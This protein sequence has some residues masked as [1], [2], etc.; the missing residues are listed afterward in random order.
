MKHI[1]V[2]G[3]GS[4][5]T[6]IANQLAFNTEDSVC[7]ICRSEDQQQEINDNHTNL[8]YFPNKT[9]H[10]S[11]RASASLSKLSDADIVFMALPTA[12][13]KEHIKDLKIAIP[14]EALVV[15]LSKGLFKNGR[16][17]VDYLKDKL[18]S[19]NVV[20]MK[21]PTF[22]V[23][24]MN[25]EHSL[26][27]LGHDTETQYHT[28][29]ELVRKTNIH[30]DHTTDIAGVELLSALKN[31]Y[32]IIMGIVDAQ[33]NAINTRHMILTKAFSEIRVL[34]EALGG[35][36]DTL[37]LACGYGDFGLTALN[38][39]SRNRT[40]GLLIGKGFY[41]SDVNQSS[42]VLEG[43]RTIELISKATDDS[44]QKQLP[45]FN[46]LESFFR[47]KESKFKIRFNSLV[48]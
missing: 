17:L 34:L 5:G 47:D 31:V 28:I 26:F 18:N 23:E 21:G 12:A 32:A 13:L 7:L 45:L 10:D 48:D 8:R 29:K 22:A 35:K 3:A 20:T 4:F 15:N 25:N 9:L 27:T 44:I 37:F 42:V 40:L 2:I 24:L 33:Y 19:P 43:L 1:Y 11:L 16:N 38:D 6:A 41:N 46:R 30:I 36:E 14:T 39:L